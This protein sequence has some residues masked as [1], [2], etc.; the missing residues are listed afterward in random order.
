VDPFQI[1]SLVIL[2]LIAVGLICLIVIIH[3]ATVRHQAATESQTKLLA[4]LIEVESAI[5]SALP[6]IERNTGASHKQLAEI[7]P[8][9]AASTVSASQQIAEALPTLVRNGTSSTHLLSEVMPGISKAVES[10]E[11]SASEMARRVPEITLRL[12]EILSQLVVLT[13][14]HDEKSLTVAGKTEGVL[15]ELRRATAEIAALRKDLVEAVKF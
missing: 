3:K 9:L 2:G 4:R 7:L 1:T 12:G 11:R 15:E 14:S 10:S 6:A 13:K 5:K 8:S